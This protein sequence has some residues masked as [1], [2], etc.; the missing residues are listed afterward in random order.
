MP[1]AVK[2]PIKKSGIS[3]GKNIKEAKNVA[4]NLLTDLSCS[5]KNLEN[6]LFL[7]RGH[8]ELGSITIIFFFQRIGKKA[9]YFKII[10]LNF[11]K[12]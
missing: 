10:D 8:L 1:R 4:R 11:N 2:K 5:R 6:F 7:G 12:H 9:E 3:S